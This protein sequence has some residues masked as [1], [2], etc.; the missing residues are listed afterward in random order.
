MSREQA[1]FCFV[2]VVSYLWDLVD[3]EPKR[4]TSHH[5][6][7]ICVDSGQGGFASALLRSVFRTLPKWCPWVVSGS[8]MSGRRRSLV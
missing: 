3:D 5:R 7:T 8:T 4:Y 6:P 2:T 1:H